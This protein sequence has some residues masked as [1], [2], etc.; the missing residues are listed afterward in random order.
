MKFLT[1][2]IFITTVVSLF[3]CGGRQGAAPQNPATVQQAACEK[4]TQTRF[5]EI[6][7]KQVLWYQNHGLAVPTAPRQAQLHFGTNGRAVVVVHGFVSSP[8]FMSDISAALVE[9]GFTVIEPLLLG[10]GSDP[11]AANAAKVADWKES[12]TDAVELAKLC[13]TD[14]SVLGHSLGSALLTDEIY[15]GQITGISHAVLLAPFYK[16]YSTW[17]TLLSSV[18]ASRVEVLDMNTFRS[19]TGG[20]DPY[21][22]LP[23][24]H[25]QPGEAE[26]YLPLPATNE[27]LSL[28]SDFALPATHKIKI[29][30]LVAVSEA[31]GVVDSAYA[32]EYAKSH[33][34]V[35]TLLIYEKAKNIV[36]SF[37]RRVYNPQFDELMHRVVTHL[38]TAL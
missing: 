17:P 33:F 28:Q 37:Q 1:Q 38:N 31:D 19:L 9:Q 21:V 14:V 11:H 18:L 22:Y 6:Q 34:E 30:V 10:F 5:S 27:A 4:T 3:G 35:P 16:S 8:E 36:H 24:D 25:P 29:P 26:P 15:S 23:V 32:L 20:L 12:V 7:A 13:H 2:L